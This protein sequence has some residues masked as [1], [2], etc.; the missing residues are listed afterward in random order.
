MA[1][2]QHARDMQFIVCRHFERKIIVII[3]QLLKSPDLCY[4]IAKIRGLC[5]ALVLL[6]VVLN[7]LSP[8]PL[9]HLML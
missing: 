6:T 9:Y 8:L 2:I 5:F 3:T 4:C 7:Y 1:E